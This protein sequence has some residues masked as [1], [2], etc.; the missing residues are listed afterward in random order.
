[1]LCII[2]VGS[3][4]LAGAANASGYQTR[5]DKSPA[6]GKR[7]SRR[8]GPL[9]MR[10]LIEPHRHSPRARFALDG[11]RLPEQAPT[12]GEEDEEC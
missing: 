6:M 3:L 12:C 4:L 8:R 7:A 2:G 5:E 10:N 9:S 1:M 11:R